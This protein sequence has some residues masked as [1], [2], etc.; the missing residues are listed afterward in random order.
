MLLC[1]AFF[2]DKS[3]PRRIFIALRA[4]SGQT[5]T[6][7]VCDN[8]DH[9][10]LRLASKSHRLFCIILASIVAARIEWSAVAVVRVVMTEQSSRVVDRNRT[11][12]LETSIELHYLQWSIAIVTKT[13]DWLIRVMLRWTD[14]YWS[15]QLSAI[16]SSHINQW[17]PDSAIEQTCVAV[18]LCKVKV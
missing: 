7:R 6:L 18:V 1:P 8:I 17:K 10:V 9:C 11:C 16:V 4:L 3:M 15:K 12:W 14:Q 5:W 13:V 2:L